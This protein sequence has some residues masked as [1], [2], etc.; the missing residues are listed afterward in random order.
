MAIYKKLSYSILTRSATNILVP[1]ISNDQDDWYKVY[2]GYHT[3]LDIEGSEIYSFQSGVVTQIGDM[4][5]GLC[6]VVI[7]YTAKTSLRYAN[8]SS[9]CIHKGDVIRQGQMIGV[10]KK[11]VHFEYLTSEKEDSM[12]PVRV[13]SNT[14]FKHNPELLIDGTV[15]LDANDWSQIQRADTTSIPYA[16]RDS[17]KSEFGVNGKEDSE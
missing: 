4:G 17:Q 14:Y 9:T 13:G 12:W 6:S 16:L 15:K 5:N 3:G 8:M 10:A 1:Y 2:G 7:Q 11:F